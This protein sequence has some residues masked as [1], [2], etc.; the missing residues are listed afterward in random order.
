MEVIPS[1]CAYNYVVTAHKPTSVSHSAVGHFT[2][3]EDLNL[4]ISKSTRLEIHKLTPQGLQGCLDVPIFGRISVV[5]LFRPRGERKDL[6]FLLTERYRFCVLEFNEA[7]R[8]LITRAHGDVADK[9]GRPCEAGQ[10]GIIDPDCRL[11]GLHLYDGHFKIIPIVDGALQEAFNVRLDELKVLDLAFLHG[12]AVP[13]LAVLFEDTKEQRH[14]KTYQVSVKDKEL[15]DGPWSEACLDSGSSLVVPVRNTSGAVVIGEQA[16]IY[17]SDSSVCS[18]SIK[19]TMVKAFASVGDD[20]SRYLLGDYLGNLF[21]LVLEGSDGLVNTLKL[22]PLGKTSQASTLSYL[23]NG[24]VFVGS[25]FGDSQL[26]RLHAQPVEGSSPDNYVEVL[27]TMTNLGPIVDFCVVDLD[28]QGQG[29]VVTCSGGGADGSLRII[30]NGI[31]FLEQASVELP[32]MK[33]IWSLRKNYADAYDTYLVM[34]FVGETRVLGMNADDE[35]DEADISGFDSA[36]QTLWCGNMLHDQIVQVTDKELRILNAETKQAVSNWAPPEGKR[37]IVV[38]GNAS[39]PITLREFKARGMSHVFAASD[40]PTV[41]YS[42]NNKLLFSN[43]NENEVSY[44]ASFNTSSFPDSLALVKPGSLSIGSMD[45]IQKLHVRT[46]PLHEQPRRITH[47]E[48]SRSFLVTI[49]QAMMGIQDPKDSVRLLDD[50]TF[51][52]LD[53]FKLNVYEMACSVSSMK[54]S[55]D[56]AEYFAVGTALAPPEELEPTKGRILLFQVHNGKLQLIS[57]KETRGAVYNLNP[58]H[59]KLLAGIN[60]RVQL[61]KWEQQDD[62][63]RQLVPECSHAGHVLVLFVD[64]RGDFILIGD[65]MKSMQLLLYKPDENKLELR[66]RDYNPSW[67]SAATFLDNDVYLGAENN[68]NLYTVRKND[69]VAEEEMR[70]RLQ[71]VGGYHLGD[72]VN[73]FQSGSLVM[74]MPDSALSNVPTKIYGSI[75]GAVGVIASI[76]AEHY[77]MLA[78]VQ[79][80]LTK[81]ISGVGGLEHKEYRSFQTPFSKNTA[82]SQGFIDGDL[83]EQIL[84]LPVEGREAVFAELKGEIDPET[85][86]QFVEELSR[87]LH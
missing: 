26:V 74:R 6:L 16:A 11:I 48:S 15:R 31:G 71:V 69:E 68:Y 84:D 7:K 25:C 50:Q 1:C 12:C 73:R 30:R 72:F 28:R 10:I 18:A 9:V 67:M 13:T 17:L 29:Q 14:I 37:I 60:S 65:L 85:V 19:P 53:V 47:Q 24:F 23:D 76:G 44:I 63:S 70:S 4:I 2:A 64:V 62:G 8:E 54:L 36:A 43:L 83:V 22:E 58:F 35:L 27:D 46:A 77:E 20:G 57:Q 80:A 79:I 66:A 51:E 21:L 40:R 42:A 75:S 78:K 61:Y 56:T 49:T 41:I 52:T 5:K 3:P 87:T 45:D 33:G 34:A 32:G 55:D 86:L 82:A 38:N 81:V 59:G 39:Q